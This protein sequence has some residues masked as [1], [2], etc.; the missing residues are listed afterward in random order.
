MVLV[1]AIVACALLVI[2]LT[3]SYSSK[4]AVLFF[5]FAA[6]LVI[7][8]V[9]LVLNSRSRLV[10]DKDGVEFHCGSQSVW[11]PW[12]L[13]N[14]AGTPFLYSMQWHA[15]VPI[16]VGALPYVE[17]RRDE[18]C[19]AYGTH[20]SISAFKLSQQTGSV[21]IRFMPKARLV[22]VANLLLALGRLLGT[23]REIRHLPSESNSTGQAPTL[24]SAAEFD[25]DWVTISITRICFPPIC[26]IC[27]SATDARLDVY[28]EDS[29]GWVISAL[30]LGH[31]HP[32]AVMVPVPFCAKCQSSHERRLRS[33]RFR[34]CWIGAGL[35]PV[36]GLSLLPFFPP[37]KWPAFLI[38]LGFLAF[39]GGLLGVGLG[40]WITG[41]IHSF[42]SGARYSPRHQTVS[43]RFRRAGYAEQV[44][45][46]VQCNE[47]GSRQRN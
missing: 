7:A 22:E 37:E 28:A 6:A 43:L 4:L 25:G 27:G 24:H 8:Y 47:E 5:S 11:C 41:S 13:F 42:V 26:C 38:L 14:V 30:T 40:S 3:E 2:Y 29:R 31:I 15:S 36:L 1:T 20:A 46:A 33:G 35:G 45:K 39:F 44:Y 23:V 21:V 17:L 12:Q 32:A 19:V 16:N 34:G 10:L 9:G 18:T